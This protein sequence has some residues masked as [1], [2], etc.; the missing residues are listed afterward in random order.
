MVFGIDDA[1]LAALIGAGGSIG[2]GLLGSGMFGGGGSK[3]KMKPYNKESLSSLLGLLS[4]QG[5]IPGSQ[6]AG[7]F[8]AGGDYIQNLLSG[9][10]EAF[11]SFEAPFK[12]Q[13]EE[14]T[15]PKLTNQFAGLG[16]GAGALSS[17]GFQN[18]LARE[19]G[20]L[21]ESLAA[22]RSGLQMQ[23]LPQALQYSQA[24]IKNMLA[25]AGLIPGQYFQK[26]G[27]PGFAQ[28]ALNS[29]GGSGASLSSLLGL[30]GQLGGGGGN[31][32]PLTSAYDTM[33][34]Q[35]GLPGF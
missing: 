14:E 32:F 18:S 17:S 12:R 5:F 31:Q 25:A 7:I 22:L 24:P 35:Q 19:G 3:T 11:K 15:I 21:S 1:V 27:Q 6:G 33:F 28:G 23:A 26:E 20:R 4:G 9:N 16:T 30:F 34:R 13:F 10:P 2:G 29:F 8:G